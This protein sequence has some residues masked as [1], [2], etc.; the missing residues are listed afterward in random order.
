MGRLTAILVALAGLAVSAHAQVAVQAHVVDG[1]PVIAVVPE[2]A[3][4]FPVVYALPGL[5]EMV[6]G[7]TASARGWVDDYG[8]VA[9]YQD[10]ALKG[11]VIVCPATPRALTGDFERYL[12]QSVIPWAEA[13]LPI[14]KGPKHRGIDGISMGGRH[15]LRIGF[16]YPEQ[17]ATIGTEQAAVGSLAPRWAR[18]IRK[19]P[20]RFAH[21]RVLLLTSNRDGFR[22]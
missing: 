8:L 16:K 1:K 11:L 10:I 9:A 21:L 3:G 17:F 6:R 20:Q 15:A 12:L 18:R 2:G 19:R 7:P 13:Q 22:R 14:R 4:P 5:G